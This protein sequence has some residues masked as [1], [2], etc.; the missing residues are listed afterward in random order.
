MFILFEK[1]IHALII[2]MLVLS[3]NGNSDGKFQEQNEVVSY[4]LEEADSSLIGIMEGEI[5]YKGVHIDTVNTDIVNHPWS[6]CKVAYMSKNRIVHYLR[7]V[8]ED[9]AP[10]YTMMMTLIV[11]EDDVFE[12]IEVSNR[13][14]IEEIFEDGDYIWLSGHFESGKMQY[15]N[16]LYLYDVNDKTTYFINEMFEKNSVTVNDVVHGHVEVI[17]KHRNDNP[18][19]SP[20]SDL[21]EEEKKYLIKT[22]MEYE[23]NVE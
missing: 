18:P 2:C 16:V 8:E 15:W 21:N 6:Y 9:I 17:V 23:E 14:V 22:D 13:F 19:F 11:I 4:C 3:P 20:N 7:I 12:K 10:P 1:V 5:Y